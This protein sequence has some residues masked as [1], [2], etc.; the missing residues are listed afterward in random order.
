MSFGEART[1][2]I[3]LGV[4]SATQKIEEDHVDGGVMQDGDREI[5][6][7]VRYISWESERE[8]ERPPTDIAVDYEHAPKA[9]GKTSPRAS[10]SHLS[11]YE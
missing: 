1:C 11:S 10:P 3:K 6:S 8:R 9:R 4:A 7:Y 2:V 5:R